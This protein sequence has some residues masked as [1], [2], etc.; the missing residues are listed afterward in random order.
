MITCKCG[1]QNDDGSRFCSE[2]GNTLTIQCPFCHEELT[3]GAN[4]CQFCGKNLISGSADINGLPGGS[5]VAGDV[6]TTIIYNQEKSPSSQLVSA[7]H[8]LQ[9]HTCGKE[10][11]QS[12]KASLQ[13][14]V[15]GLYFCSDHIDIQN[16]IC[17]SCV[18]KALSAFE[19]R[20]YDNGKYAILSVKNK[21]TPSITIPSCVESIEDEAF[22]GCS[23]LTVT[24]PNGL[25]KI[26]D[27][28]FA[29]CK[30]LVTVRFPT[31][32]K[33]IGSEAFRNCEKLNLFSVPYGVTT[34]ENAFIGTP[35]AHRQEKLRSSLDKAKSLPGKF[36][37]YVDPEGEVKQKSANVVNTVKEQI[38]TT[39]QNAVKKISLFAKISAYKQAHLQGWYLGW[40]IF[41]LILGFVSIATLL[42]PITICIL[43]VAIYYCVKY[44]RF[45][46]ATQTQNQLPP[47]NP[48]EQL[49]SA[50]DLENNETNS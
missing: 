16:H 25:L 13:C 1:H 43:P 35:L 47:D 3:P 19:C 8:T 9:C 45:H 5:V 20:Q 50:D 42:I 46:A 2:C 7:E 30:E 49:S 41:W 23:A 29:D 38:E 34:G 10:I 26:G 36:V 22:L 15:C 39:K 32:L 24:L 33:F 11:P 21:D 17:P 12:A 44:S 6:H 40:M 37:K 48:P 18:Q 14:S 28:A 27:R 4:F 31:S